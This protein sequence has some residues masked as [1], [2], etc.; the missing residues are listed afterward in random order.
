MISGVAGMTR[1]EGGQRKTRVFKLTTETQGSLP[2]EGELTARTAVRPVG[3][4]LA[5]PSRQQA[6]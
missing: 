3:D 2:R 4:L 1:R 5:M 6:S